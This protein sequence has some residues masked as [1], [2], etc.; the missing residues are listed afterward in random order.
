MVRRRG[1]TSTAGTGPLPRLWECYKISGGTP[2]SAIAVANRSRPTPVTVAGV[3]TNSQYV[4]N[5][6]KCYD[7]GSA[8]TATVTGVGLDCCKH[9][10]SPVSC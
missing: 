4:R 6:P 8:R 1:L 5:F 9:V 7:V 2:R 3:S 10:N